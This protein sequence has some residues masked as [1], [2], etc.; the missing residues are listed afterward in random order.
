M[1]RMFAVQQKCR[2]NQCFDSSNY[3]IQPLNPLWCCSSFTLR[4]SNIRH[5]SVSLQFG[6]N[7]PE[8]FHYLLFSNLVYFECAHF[9]HL[10]LPI[11]LAA[12]IQHGERCLMLMNDRDPKKIRRGRYDEMIELR[13]CSGIVREMGTGLVIFSHS[14]KLRHVVLI[15]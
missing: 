8:A 1:Q 12:Y 3:Y 10:R 9:I 2:R 5:R 15:K 7:H 4:Q 13:E 14:P 11:N 6:N